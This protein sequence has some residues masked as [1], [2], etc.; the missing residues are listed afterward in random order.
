MYTAA[1]WLPS[2]QSKWHHTFSMQASVNDFV[3]KAAA[4]ALQD[5]PLANAR[6]DEKN[7]EI[8]KIDTVDIA[9][10]VAT[11]AGEALHQDDFPVCLD[12]AAASLVSMLQQKAGANKSLCCRSDHSHSAKGQ[13]KAPQPDLSGGARA[14]RA[15]A[16]QQ[17]QAPRVPGRIL[18]H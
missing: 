12:K 7:E 11:D 16:S 9:I 3:V 14:G 10:A 13:H 18:Q 4:L 17:T 8:V 15:G 5:V 1:A 6:W 2:A